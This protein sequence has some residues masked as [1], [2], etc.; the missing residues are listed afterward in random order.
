M[1]TL[2]DWKDPLPGFVEADLVSHCGGTATGSFAYTLILTDIASGWTECVALLV[3]AASIIMEAF[4][5]LPNAMPFPLRGIDTGS[6][7]VNA[8][9]VAYLA[10]R[11][12]QAISPASATAIVG[13]IEEL[14]L[15]HVERG[16][17]TKLGKVRDIALEVIRAVLR[18]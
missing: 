2:C 11:R 14:L 17:Q 10:E 7:F 3:R 1:R 15:A 9:L 4:E 16:R 12:V 6:D 8:T 13:G 5:R 18:P